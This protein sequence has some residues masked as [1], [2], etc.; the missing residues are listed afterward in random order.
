MIKIITIHAKNS[1]DFLRNNGIGIITD[2]RSSPN[3][4]EATNGEFYIEFEY[5]YNGKNSKYL[6]EENIIVSPVGYGDRQAFRISKSKKIIDKSYIYIYVYAKHISYD[7]VDNVIED[8]Y[9]QDKDGNTAID[10]ILSHTQYKHN[11]KSYSDIPVRNNA[12]Y[13][14]KNPIQALISDDENSF[15]KRWGGE[16]VRDNFLIKMLQARGKDKGVYI[17][18]RKNL[19]GINFETDFT[20]IATRVRPIGYDGMELPE[21]YV[22]SLLINNYVNPKIKSLEYSDIK[23]KA[24][25]ANEDG[26][27]TLEECYIEMRKRVMNE[28]ENGLDKPKISATV[29]FIEL[30]KTV[31]YKEYKGLE[32]LSIGDTVHIYIDEFNLD[33]SEKVI[34][35]NYN[36]ILD[37]YTSFELGKE[38][39]SYTLESKNY[40]K[41]LEEVIIPNYLD[42]AKKNATD[43]LTT[44]LGGYIVKTRNEFFILDNEDI[45]KAEKIWR[46][47]INGLGYSKTGINGTYE[48]AVTADGQI[49]ADFIT[50]GTMSVDRIEGLSNTLKQFSKIILEMDKISLIVS[51]TVDITK[52]IENTSHILKLE[53]CMKGNLLE[54]RISGDNKVFGETEWNID[55]YFDKDTTFYGKNNFLK[56]NATNLKNGI[57]Y[58]TANLDINNHQFNTGLQKCK[59]LIIPIT[60]NRT[61]KVFKNKGN[62]FAL[63]TFSEDPKQSL[64]ATNYVSDENEGKDLTNLTITSSEKDKYLVVFFYDGNLDTDLEKMYDSIIVYSGYQEI[65]LGLN[66]KLR[67]LELERINEKGESEKYTIEDKI[68]FKNNCFYLIKRIGIDDNENLYVLENEEVTVL[69]EI[70]INLEEGINTIE[71][72]DYYSPKMYA[73]YVITNEYTKLFATSVDM[74]A[75][76]E[77]LSNSIKFM[78]TQNNILASVNLAIKNGQ[79]VIEVESNQFSLKSDYLT[80][81][82]DGKITATSGKI[83]QWNLSENYIS[84]NYN[85]DNKKYQSGLFARENGYSSDIFLYAGVPLDG[86]LKD[87]NTYITHDGKI[88]AKWFSVNGESG[89]FYIDYNSGN[90]ALSFDKDGIRWK[91][92]NENNNNFSLLWKGS[93]GMYFEL[94]DAPKFTIRDAVHDYINI[95]DIV[96]YNPNSNSYFE[97]LG[98]SIISNSDFRIEGYRYDGINYTIRIQGYEV[99]T[100]ASDERLKENIENCKMS[101][102]NIVNNYRIV[103]FDWKKNIRNKDA[104]KH[105]DFGIIAQEAEKVDKNSVLHDE[106]E[107]TWQMRDLNLINTL[108]KAMQEEDKKVEFLINKLGYKEEV[109]NI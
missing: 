6:V 104:G 36:P 55:T 28:Y 95:L 4:R 15:L 70:P 27:D 91:L 57:Q 29:N 68:E 32:K 14:F 30:A 86:Y 76:I 84:H 94:Y 13:V 42:V 44:A 1:T 107:D 80:I 23:L 7:L 102:L 97:N 35:T 98:N 41:K 17:R 75:K 59:S 10:W 33:I 40:E 58:I 63:G 52:E 56:I 38:F 61:Y 88:K 9:I 45:N 46:W 69:K 105:I 16:I 3:V 77:M 64:I 19:K 24:N 65:D 89:Y 8:S 66:E 37:K 67:C 21:K 83:G 25:N 39:S 103:S 18:Y 74:N 78:V 51:N 60:E 12:R 87:A 11:F 34:S 47:N 20:G 71:I 96:K 79:G 100:S 72:A 5:N 62:R 50:T 99:Q 26:F 93:T 108:L 43:L 101:A 106:K 81:T 73:K 82:K 54:F 53:N 90:R 85:I 49:V 92:D 31:E 2:F 48:T 22:D 109:K